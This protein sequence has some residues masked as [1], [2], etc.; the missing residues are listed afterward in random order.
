M[1]G[2]SFGKQCC[3]VE[4]TL[5]LE[6]Q[7]PL[8]KRWFHCCGFG[9]S[10]EPLF[11]HLKIGTT[12]LALHNHHAGC[13]RY[14]GSLWSGPRHR[15]RARSSP[16]TLLRFHKLKFLKG[17]H[18]CPAIFPAAAKTQKSVLIEGTPN[19]RKWKVNRA[20]RWCHPAAPFSLIQMC[21]RR[22][23]RRATVFLRPCPNHFSQTLRFADAHTVNL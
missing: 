6:S 8:R 16:P 18:I 12:A 21:P 2:V 23:K 3:V 20:G 10:S 22:T 1:S 19:R 17:E 4:R 14:T 11:L 13:E 9:Q 15:A 7:R 5:S